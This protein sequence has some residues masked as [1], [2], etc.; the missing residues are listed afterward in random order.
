MTPEVM[1]HFWPRHAQMKNCAGTLAYLPEPPLAVATDP[2]LVQCAERICSITT[3]TDG[4]VLAGS[5]LPASTQHRNRHDAA[6]PPS[7]RSGGAC[8]R[9]TRP[10]AIPRPTPDLAHLTAM[11]EPPGSA[12]LTHVSGGHVSAGTCTPCRAHPTRPPD[13]IGTHPTGHGHASL[14]EK[15][16]VTG[17][18]RT[19]QRG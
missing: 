2:L 10:R 3:L 11:F 1:P 17:Q 12:E 16:S 15:P 13:L 9:H 7:R 6:R 5:A 19:P 8:R 4:I 18:E 14:F